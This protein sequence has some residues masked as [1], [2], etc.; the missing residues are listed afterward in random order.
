M[1]QFDK[2]ILKI[3]NLDKDLRFDELK[4]VLELYGYEMKGPSGGSSHITFRKSGNPPIT[5][6]KHNPIK[7]VYV[8]IIKE[9]IEESEVKKNGKE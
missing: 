5:I 7:R 9:I 3:R 1:S 8:E 6:P 2:L 4:K